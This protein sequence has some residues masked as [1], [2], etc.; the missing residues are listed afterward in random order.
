MRVTNF[1]SSKAQAV[2]KFTN[3][4][5]AM[6]TSTITIAGFNDICPEMVKIWIL[7]LE[8][9]FEPKLYQTMCTFIWYIIHA[10]EIMLVDTGES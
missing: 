2:E 7:D 3:K 10:F 4:Y 9:F 6:E 8:F 5:L 1:S